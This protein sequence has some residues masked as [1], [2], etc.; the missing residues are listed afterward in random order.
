MRKFTPW[1]LLRR[2]L[3]PIADEL[4]RATPWRIEPPATVE[5]WLLG[6]TW[7]ELQFADIAVESLCEEPPML[8][9][10][11]GSLT[12]AVEGSPESERFQE[13]MA[14][15][16]MHRIV[17]AIDLSYRLPKGYRDGHQLTGDY[18]HDSREVLIYGWRSSSASYCAHHFGRLYCERAS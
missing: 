9:G 2:R 13:R 15:H 4:H 7:R 5:S 14:Q 12:A 11:L 1:T 8:D 3:E 18:P 6:L 16:V 10:C 17:F